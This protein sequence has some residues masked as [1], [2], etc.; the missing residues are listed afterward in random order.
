L[1]K[2]FVGEQNVTSQA[3]F[4]DLNV[5]GASVRGAIGKGIGNLEVGYYESADDLSGKNNLIDNSQ[6]WYLIGYTRE[7]E[8]DFTAG[9]QYYVEQMM[10]YSQYKS[11]LELIRI[12][13]SL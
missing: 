12:T 5:Y 1:Q 4:P 11:N 2:H 9:V 3:I 6:M 13:G 8:K 7:I 10:D